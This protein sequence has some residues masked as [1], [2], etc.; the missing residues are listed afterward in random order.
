MRYNFSSE[1]LFILRALP[2]FSQTVKLSSSACNSG[3]IVLQDDL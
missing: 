3:T 1:E 2:L